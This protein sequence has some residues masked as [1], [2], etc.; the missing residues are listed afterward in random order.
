MAHFARIDEYNV[1][2]EIHV[3]NNDDIDGGN[4]PES[5]PLGQTLQASLGLGETWLQ[6][7]YSASFRG[8]YPGLGW[9][10]DQTLD[11]FIPTPQQE[12]P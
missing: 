10:Y 12:T 1:I 2:Q 3:I 5:E 6:C 7:S 11:E 4:Y 8:A 9:S